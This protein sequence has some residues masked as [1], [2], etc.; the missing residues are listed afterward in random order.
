M[1]I[2]QSYIDAAT[3]EVE[4]AKPL[5][6][7]INGET[8]EFT[9][10]EYQQKI[11]DISVHK[12]NEERYGYI[13]NRQLN[14]P[15]LDDFAEAYTEKFIGEDSAKWDAYVTKYNQVRSDFP[16]PVEESNSAPSESEAPA[17]ETEETEN[18]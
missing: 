2:P 13:V 1:S 17:E 6:T 8:R 11:D 14:Y 9:E 7:N 3:E 18:P 10:E 12:Y 5:Y 4:N 16:K 15:S